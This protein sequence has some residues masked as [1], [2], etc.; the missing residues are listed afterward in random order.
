MAGVRETTP[1]GNSRAKIFVRLVLLRALDEI[2]CHMTH[3]CF[4]PRDRESCNPPLKHVLN[5]ANDP[6]GYYLYAESS[7][8]RETEIAAKQKKLGEKWESRQKQTEQS[9]YKKSH[10]NDKTHKHLPT[11]KIFKCILHWLEK[12]I[13]SFDTLCIEVLK[14]Q[15]NPT[16]SVLCFH[17]VFKGPCNTHS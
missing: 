15:I 1:C 7:C 6:G 5:S 3:Q 8:L 10:R 16:R 2:S 4:L 9:V 13:S 12:C 17:F 11:H 14:S